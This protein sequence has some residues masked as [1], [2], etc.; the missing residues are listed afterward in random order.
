[1]VCTKSKLVR[2]SSLVGP[3]LATMGEDSAALTLTHF[4]LSVT[5][6][7]ILPATSSCDSLSLKI[8]GLTIRNVDQQS[9]NM[10]DVF[11]LIKMAT[12]S[13]QHIQI[14]ADEV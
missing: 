8:C 9:I 5:H 13:M 3:V 4:H 11:R 10:A 7:L 14:V 1:M 12:D 6:P 2:Q